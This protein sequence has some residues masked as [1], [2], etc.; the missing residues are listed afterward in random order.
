MIWIK[1]KRDIVTMRDGERLRHSDSE[2]WGDNG[3]HLNKGEEREVETM[4]DEEIMVVI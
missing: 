3:S 1:E 4:R 2:R